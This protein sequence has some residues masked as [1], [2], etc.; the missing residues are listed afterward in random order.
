[1]IEAVN[2]K[3]EA[4]EDNRAVISTDALD[5]SCTISLQTASELRNLDSREREH[6]KLYT[7]LHHKEDSMELYGFYDADERM[8]FFE[9]I[10]VQGVGP[11][12]A[13]KILSGIQVTTLAAALDSGDITRLS[14]IPGLGTKTAQKMVLS[15]RNRL[16]IFSKHEESSSSAQSMPKVCKEILN[17][18]TEMG[19]DRKSAK[20]AVMDSYQRF[21][22]DGADEKT[23]E[24]EIFRAALIKLA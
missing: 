24:H 1:M 21:Y 5:F 22:Y 9:L 14:A 18:L 4:V 17:A 13:L 19:Y 2:G 7:F 16:E 10:K 11:K 6:I 8:M 20:E 23:L 15:L 12:Q 3:L